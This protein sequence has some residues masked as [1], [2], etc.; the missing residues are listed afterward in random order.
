[1]DICAPFA[2]IV[3]FHVSAGDPVD[4]GDPLATVEAVKLEA[5]CSHP[6]PAPSPPSPSRTSATLGGDLLL[7]VRRSD[8]HHL[9]EAR[10]RKIKVP[11]TGTRPTSDR[12]REGLFSLLQCAFG[13]TTPAS[14]TSSPVPGHSAWRLLP[15]CSPRSSSEK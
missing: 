1:M 6:A 13:F 8:P 5:R 9:R 4:T 15:R 7:E 11:P 3:R 12:A 2:G 14:S 10:G